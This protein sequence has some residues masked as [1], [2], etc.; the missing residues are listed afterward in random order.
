[1]K[2]GIG[3]SFKDDLILLGCWKMHLYIR[4]AKGRAY[5][6]LKSK[7]AEGQYSSLRLVLSYVRS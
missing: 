1:M 5:S 3:F 6:Y 2:P 4:E 7:I